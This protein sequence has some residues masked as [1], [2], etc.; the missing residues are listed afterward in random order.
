MWSNRVTRI[1]LF[2]QDQ[3]PNGE[4]QKQQESRL[5]FLQ[6]KRMPAFYAEQILRIT[7]SLP[8]R[9]MSWNA[10]SSV[11]Y[12]IPSG[13]HRRGT[14]VSGETKT[15]GKR[16][17]L[18]QDINH[19]SLFLSL[20]LQIKHKDST[21]GF[22]KKK[23]KRAFLCLK[24]N[25]SVFCKD[26]FTVAFLC[27]GYEFHISRGD[28][29]RLFIMTVLLF[30]NQWSVSSPPLQRTGFLSRLWRIREIFRHEAPSLKSLSLRTSK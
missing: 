27:R 11:G 9:V 8:L 12:H 7:K 18:W 2:A 29:L 3:K 15:L 28:S 24:L 30:K 26:S 5:S 20:Y 4:F 22:L 13:P 10:F 1:H 16:A 21:Q 23:K 19:R 14:R 25:R 6:V 17:Q